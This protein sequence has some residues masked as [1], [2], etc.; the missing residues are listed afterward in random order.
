VRVGRGVAVGCGGVAVAGGGG[1]VGVL[2]GGGVAVAGRGVAVAGCGRVG[3]GVGGG[4][5]G[6]GAWS[7][8]SALATDTPTLEVTATSAS[9]PMRT[10]ART[11]NPPRI[12]KTWDMPETVGWGTR[13]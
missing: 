13:G 7:P 11:G 2:A 4:N 6:L 1:D 5:V 9:T 3:A 8:G 12:K 10:K